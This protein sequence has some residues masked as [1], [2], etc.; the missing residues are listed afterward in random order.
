M[1]LVV[2]ALTFLHEYKASLLH[3]IPNKNPGALRLGVISSAAINAAA[4][5]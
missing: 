2:Q 1:A 3:P 5:M 4:G